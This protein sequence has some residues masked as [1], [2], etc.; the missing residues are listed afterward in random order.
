MANKEI[1]LQSG[2][3]RFQGRASSRSKGKKWNCTDCV[4]KKNCIKSQILVT[5][6]NSNTFNQV[7]IYKLSYIIN[8]K[9]SMFQNALLALR[10]LLRIVIP[11]K[12]LIS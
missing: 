4:G 3:S 1:K 6:N 10:N 9:L 5:G 2:D 12:Q 11:L 8:Y 7:Q